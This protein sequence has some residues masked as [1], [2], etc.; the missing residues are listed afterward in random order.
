MLSVLDIF[1]V[2]IGPSSSH[3]VGPMRIAEKFMRALGRSPKFSNVYR[4]KF[5]LRGSLA[6]T[7]HGHGTPR[8]VLLGALGFRPETINLSKAEAALAELGASK[9]LRLRSG[10][11]VSFDPEA[12]VSFDYDIEAELHPNEMYCGAF[13]E[14]GEALLERIY[15]STGGGFIASRKQLLHPAKAD[16]V[17][18]GK[19]VPHP[20]GSCAELLAICN[21]QK[22]AIDEIIL[23]N[24]DAMRPRADTHAD[25]LKIYT[26]MMESIDRGLCA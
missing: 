5:G 25:I 24:E 14:S 1:R 17:S 18:T 2:G 13:D 20:F 4:I 23:R 21:E 22:R 10:R 8:A 9:R 7:G 11:E 26:T 12:D 16:R 6:F 15:Y 3:T 19:S